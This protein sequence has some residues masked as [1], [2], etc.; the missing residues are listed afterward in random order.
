MMNTYLKAIEEELSTTF[1]A[2]LLQKTVIDA[3]NY[4]LLAGGKRI[5]PVLTLEFCRATCGTWEQALP[6]G[7]ALEMIHTYSLIHDDLPCMDDDDFRRG[8]PTNHKVFG[9]A[10]A[11]LAGDGLL[12][13]AFTKATTAKLPAETLVACIRE[14][15]LC[16][17]EVGMVGGQILDIEGE[18]RTL[19][20]D[21]IHE[22]QR[23][24]TGKLLEAACV[25][26]TMAGGG[27][28]AQVKAART[29]A[30]C[31]GLA[32]QTQDDI[33]DV[34]GDAEKL[35]KPVGTDANKNTFVRLYGLER[36]RAMVEDETQKGI[37]AL[38][39]FSGPAFLVDLA[40]KLAQRDH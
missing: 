20:G 12:T 27:T 25:M 19:E 17:G 28:E 22:I 35:G 26:G 8:R 1:Q 7:C 32:F 9:E 21:Y 13:A 37:A 10:M 31:L 23:L 34:I 14:L 11:V 38:S 33:L 30:K 5:R 29:Y 3:M 16:A 39:A 15:S 18:H 24:K 2:D 6:L 40:Q 4:S 36:C